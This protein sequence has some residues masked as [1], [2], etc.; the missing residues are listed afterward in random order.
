M[1]KVLIFIIIIIM[2]IISI[3]I[4]K[5][6]TTN[7]IIKNKVILNSDGDFLLYIDEIQK[8]GENLKVKGIVTK[9]TININNE[10]SIVGLGMKGIDCKVIKL[11]SNNT[12]ID[13]AK[14]GDSIDITLE[15]FVKREYIKEGQAIITPKSTKPIFSIEAEIVSTNLSLK[16][17]T[18]KGNKFYINS[19][20]NCSIS[21]ISEEEKI[22]KI[23]LEE[24]MVVVE[25]LEVLIKNNNNV[26]A[27]CKVNK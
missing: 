10:I 12:T 15:S 6:H 23:K 19:D 24:S 26:I 8:D 27:N 14:A 5:N 9:G 4:Y 16:E 3:F 7:N 11:E 22:I 17:I 20:I 1:K 21:I 18:E 13:S 25:E 2:I